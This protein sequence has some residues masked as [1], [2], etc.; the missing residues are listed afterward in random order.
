MTGTPIARHLV[1]GL[2]FA[3]VTTLALPG[4][5]FGAY[6]SA[7]TP[8]P[9]TPSGPVHVVEAAGD[10]LY[11]GTY[12]SETGT[13]RV[14][15]LDAATGGPVWSR[16]VPGLD[17][18]ALAVS[19]DGSR[20]YV[21][22][23]PEDVAGTPPSKNVFAL[24]SADGSD[25][26]SWAPDL[27]DRKVM[28]LLVVGDTV[29]AAGR[30]G[31]VNGVAQRGLAALDAQTGERKGAFD[32]GVSGGI[33]VVNSLTRVG[34][35]LVVAGK[36]T[37]V[38]GSPRSSL[39][40]FDLA[41]GALQAWAPAR[42]CATCNSYWDIDTDG[43]NVYVA[44]SGPGGYLAAFNLATGRMPWKPV[45]A[46]GDVQSV[47]VGSDGL[48]Y[49][50]GHFTQYFGN[51]DTPRVELAA[52]ITATGV[53]DP[54]FKPVVVHRHPGVKALA[55]SGGRLLA[56][57]YFA[58]VR[59]ASGSTAQPRL[60]TFA[61]RAPLAAGQPTAPGS[62]TA[63]GP[64]TGLANC[65]GVGRFDVDGDGRLDA[66]ALARRG[67]NGAFRGASIVRVQ[68]Y[69]GKV[70]TVRVANRRWWGDPWQGA[71]TLDSR[72]GRDLMVGREMRG[73]TTTFRALTWRNGRLVALDAPGRP[74]YWQVSS[75]AK[76]KAGW[77]KPRRA[78]LGTVV[79]R[80]A[81]RTGGAGTPYRG[82]VTTYRWSNRGW[83]A[84]GTRTRYPMSQRAA[85]QWGGFSVKGMSRW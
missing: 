42:V 11:V 27:G 26:G 39:A 41:T 74:S 79:R 21:G 24:A 67:R 14:T 76:V 30:F 66:V 53:V 23:H 83:V 64:C 70:S 9:W 46:S 71:A 17:V 6:F 52:V 56:G 2:F 78:P 22:G 54:Y 1:L 15:A 8:R 51:D 37:A 20:L 4:G 84:K 5:A 50:G 13:G 57:G 12:V 61:S 82:K 62:R 18:L 65:R 35:R 10:R 25:D 72:K 43:R 16:T 28:D 80:V 38:D 45:R 69:T 36:F 7:P 75:R 77:L 60:A 59:T 85:S 68:T 48:V 29:Y 34:G 47:S 3:L 55:Q 73:R 81:T 63:P 19:A 33:P 32:S 58:G 40:S 44:S 31:R 49:A